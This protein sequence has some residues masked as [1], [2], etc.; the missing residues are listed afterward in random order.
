MK[1]EP[2]KD[3]LLFVVIII[4]SYKNMITT[5]HEIS[6]FGFNFDRKSTLAFNIGVVTAASSTALASVDKNPF[7]GCGEAIIKG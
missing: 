6:Y 2:K 7:G 5:Y 3:I 1:L 4:L